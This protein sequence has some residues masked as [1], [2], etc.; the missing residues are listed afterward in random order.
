MLGRDP[1]EASDLRALGPGWAAN[2]CSRQPSD[3]CGGV[4]V[5]GGHPV[6]CR[7]P[8]SVVSSVVMGRRAGA[9]CGAPVLCGDDTGP[10]GEAHVRSTHT[11]PRHTRV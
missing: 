6:C 10:Q 11:G 1:L 2:D 4:C 5:G 9:D 3:V 8:S 7:P